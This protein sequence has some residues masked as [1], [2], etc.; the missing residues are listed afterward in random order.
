MVGRVV[1]DVNGLRVSRPGAEVTTASAEN[2][3]FNSN[4]GKYFAP[5]IKGAFLSSSFNTIYD[6]VSGSS[7]SI[8]ISKH[9][10]YVDFGRTLS[11]IPVA[12][13]MYF[14]IDGPIAGQWVSEYD[15]KVQG[16]SWSQQV[17]CL[18]VTQ[19]SRLVFVAYRLRVAGGPGYL[20]LPNV[21]YVVGRF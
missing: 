20:A 12:L 8:F 6:S 4:N 15:V 1:V 5:L 16:S 21:S 10:A 7:S 14:G 13:S 2:L 17:S 3:T 11:Y 9:E 19:A 18:M